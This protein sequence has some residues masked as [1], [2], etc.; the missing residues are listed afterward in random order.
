MTVF[1]KMFQIVFAVYTL[2]FTNKHVFGKSLNFGL[3]FMCLLKHLNLSKQTIK[4]MFTRLTK[5]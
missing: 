1:T 3:K 4:F 2:I 5:Y